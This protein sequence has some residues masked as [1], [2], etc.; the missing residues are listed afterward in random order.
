[1]RP[2]NAPVSDQ[3][4]LEIK[5]G[6]RRFDRKFPATIFSTDGSR[7]EI[8]L[9]VVI[10]PKHDS[11]LLARI[12]NSDR[13]RL[14]RSVIFHKRR[15]ATSARSSH[16]SVLRSP[17]RRRDGEKRT[18]DSIDFLPNKFSRCGTSVM[19]RQE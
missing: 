1:T 2:V 9:P 16:A 12:D 14:H 7:F 17:P 6:M 10:G 19:S 18:V 4:W 11:A 8:P 13:L 5:E 3:E 15:A